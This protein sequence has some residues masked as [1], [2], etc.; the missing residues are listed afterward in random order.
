MSIRLIEFKTS[1]LNQYTFCR[2]IGSMNKPSIASFVDE[3]GYWSTTLLQAQNY[4][5]NLQRNKLKSMVH[6]L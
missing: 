4:A 3:T 2:C 6:I 1:N 5:L